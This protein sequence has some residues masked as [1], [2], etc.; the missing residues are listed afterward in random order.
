MYLC[1]VG[2]LALFL[3]KK[4]TIANKNRGQNRRDPRIFLSAEVN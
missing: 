2:L 4:I 3:S 1:L